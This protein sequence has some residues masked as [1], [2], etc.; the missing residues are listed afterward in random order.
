MKS[1]YFFVGIDVSKKKLDVALRSR[2]AKTQTFTNDEQGI[3]SLVKHVT[4]SKKHKVRVV[5]EATNIFHFDVAVALHQ[6]P[7]NQVMVLNPRA[8]KHFAEVTM[9][10]AKTDRVD[11]KLL[12]LFGERMEFTAWEP[13]PAQVLELRTL[14]RRVHQLI[15]Q[16][17]AEKTRLQTM[18]SSQMWGQEICLSLHK[19]LAFIEQEVDV[20][21]DRCLVLIQ[22]IER[23]DVQYNLL[24]SICGFGKS[25]AIRL[26]AELAVI[27]KGLKAKQ[28]VAYSGLDPR[29]LE[30]GKH[31]NQMGPRKISKRG[32]KYIR[33][34]LYMPAVC[35]IGHQ[36][37][38]QAYYHHLLS[39]KK[40]KKL[41]L[42]AVMRKL[43]HAIWGMF[44]HV[45]PFDENK[46]Y[47]L[48]GIPVP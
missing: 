24:R 18:K 36:P 1:S 12:A 14:T 37:R 25:S 13:P 30:T 43:L 2:C 39:N 16:K 15:D 47:R 10:R 35:A 6:H 42:V 26:L 20:L 22:E 27:P 41:A 33:K 46:F 40:E 38:I 17:S 31:A 21:E 3:M 23:L 45:K 4:K 34:I 8:S 29:P 48:P 11:A 5:L 19:H 7:R 28:W 9:Q 32:N 44:H